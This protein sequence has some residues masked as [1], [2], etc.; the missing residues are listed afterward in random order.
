METINLFGVATPYAAE[1]VETCR[2]LEVAFNSVNNLGEKGLK[3]PRLVNDIDLESGPCV[4]AP[5]GSGARAASVE[6]AFALGVRRFANL[7]DP[8]STIASSTEL[9]CGN[10]VNSLVSI[11]SNS[12]LGCHIN[13][14]RSS[15]IGHNNEIGSF[16]SIGPGAILC[17]NVKLGTGTFIGAGAII[18]PGLS[19]GANVAIG[20][21]AIVTSNVP[22][23]SFLIGNPG[24]VTGKTAD[25]DYLESCPVC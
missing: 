22:D 7:L 18:L 23:G 4:V 16:C 6:A 25:W 13:I 20:A 24:R 5:S 19:I 17:G 3:L 9:G 21:G 2:R 15:S 12:E 14:N 10:Y 11:G 8:T 1:L